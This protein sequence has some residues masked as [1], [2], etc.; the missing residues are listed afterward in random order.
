[1]CAMGQDDKG[2][3]ATQ[4]T[5]VVS[6]E[7]GTRRTEK[8]TIYPRL[9]CDTRT[10]GSLEIAELRNA[11]CRGE[12]RSSG[13]YTSNEREEDWNIAFLAQVASNP[14]NEMIVLP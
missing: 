6:K 8:V 13:Q 4:S 11:T 10:A 7:V 1:M 14:M 2:Q 3:R 5:N 12:S 9:R